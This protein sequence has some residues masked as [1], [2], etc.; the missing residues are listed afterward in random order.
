MNHLPKI[1]AVGILLIIYGFA[2]PP[3]LSDR[4]ASQ[5]SS[6][7]AFLKQTLPAP[8][9]VQPR[10]V[11]DVHPQYAKLSTWISSIGAAAA[12]FDYDGDG[13]NNDIAHIDPR[14]DR[15][16]VMPAPNTGNR[17]ASIELTPKTLPF[18]RAT[19][20]PSGTL[21]NDFNEDG[22]V[23]VLVHYLGRSPIIFYQTPTGFQE[24]EL[25]DRAVSFN[26]STGTIA[27]L[28]GDGHADIFVGNYFPDATKLYDA[29]ATD[30]DQ[31]MQHSMSR[32][33][34]GAPNR[35]FLWKG[36]Q[37][38]KAQFVE[39]KNWLNGLHY[40]NDWTLAVAAA[41]LN[42]DMMPELYIA[43]DFGPDKLLLNTSKPGSFAL[44]FKEVI[45]E[46]HL[47]TLRSN[48]LGKDSFKGM[49]VDIADMNQDGLLDIFVSNI[50]DNYALHESHFA[51]INNGDVAALNQG[52]APFENKSEPMGLSRSSWA[53]DS[54]VVDFNNDGTPEAVQA[55]GFVKGTINRWPEL[56][57]LATAN[58]EVLT[59]PEVWP[60]L[61]P[62]AD[63]SGDAHMPIF[64]KS[65]SG[66]YFDLS[67][68]LGLGDN[69][70]TRGIAIS[71]VDHDGKL[72]FMSANQWEDSRFYHN[73]SQSTNQFVGLSVQYALAPLPNGKP[74][75]D[76]R[77]AGRSATGAVVR[78]RVPGRAG[79]LVSYVDGGNGH[80][81]KNSNEVHF[82]LGKFP[83]NQPLDVEITWHDAQARIQK[84]T[85]R[86]TPGWHR[87]SLPF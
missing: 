83:A 22:R 59:K 45:G 49:G 37:N 80:T 50:A 77:V 82:G 76:S 19:M 2:L 36:V 9:D 57:E 31:I 35:I 73:K 28:N 86:L 8:T 79:T 68:N 13:L 12:F 62:G 34:N 7:F 27:D 78:V 3:T 66:R 10:Y 55:T 24:A 16:T 38:G 71:D 23:D 85:A 84:T 42:N 54:K 30:R 64:V 21:A 52:V 29:S 48:V 56:Q 70:I 33:D 75:I 41:D 69:Q 1:L 39:D 17:Y 74:Q 32:G 72:D 43:N 81:G 4:E 87:V 67:M 53:W 6:E 40:P 11:R 18:N 46:K 60:R 58:D 14:F 25:C 51:F 61:T 63:I 20:A 15:V 65:K 26:S 5:L 44:S 47:T